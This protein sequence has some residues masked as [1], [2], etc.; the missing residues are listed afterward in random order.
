M[1]RRAAAVAVAA[2]A[3]ACMIPTSGAEVT[4]SPSEA[5]A[6]R[7]VV[8]VHVAEVTDRME[9]TQAE[10]VASW[11]ATSRPPRASWP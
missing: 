3:L 2:T 9:D 4:L 11:P 1:S 5:R 10:V 8:L 6:R 7:A